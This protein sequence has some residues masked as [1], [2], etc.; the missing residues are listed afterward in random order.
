MEWI[1]SYHK[2]GKN[3]TRLGGFGF[4]SLV[5]F[6]KYTINQNRKMKRDTIQFVR[7]NELNVVIYKYIFFALTFSFSQRHISFSSLQFAYVEMLDE[8]DPLVR[9]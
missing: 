4:G 3:S 8:I 1:R 9:P 6:N 2:I 7:V 5:N